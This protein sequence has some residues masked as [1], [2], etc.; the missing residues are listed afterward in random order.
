MTLQKFSIFRENISCRS[1]GIGRRKGLKIPRGK[2]R[3][4]SSPAFGTNIIKVLQGITEKGRVEI[5][6]FS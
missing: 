2:P 6:E 1:G 3:A 4:G 5:K